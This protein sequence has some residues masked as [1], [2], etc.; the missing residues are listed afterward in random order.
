[1]T[2]HSQVGQAR[3]EAVHLAQRSGFNDSFVA[4]VAL[5]TT[6]LGTNLVKYATAAQLLK[7]QVKKR[8]SHPQPSP[9]SNLRQGKV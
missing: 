9:S 5:I 4:N 3:R 7:P 1:M 8:V 2:D 6:E